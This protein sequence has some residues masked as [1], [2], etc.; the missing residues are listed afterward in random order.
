MTEYNGW[1]NYETWRIQLEMIDGLGLEFFSN[2]D[3]ENLASELETYVAEFLESESK[4]FALDLA[5][6][7]ISKVNWGELA[8]HMLSEYDEEDEENEAA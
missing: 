2:R 1:T 4:G 5:L 6:S 7:F 8:N 3:E